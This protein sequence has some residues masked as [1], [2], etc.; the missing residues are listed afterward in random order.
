MAVKLT[1]R[2]SEVTIFELVERLFLERRQRRFL[3]CCKTT[4]FFLQLA[5]AASVA[6]FPEYLVLILIFFRFICIAW[7]GF[8]H[9]HIVKNYAK[10]KSSGVSGTSSVFP[11]D[12]KSIS[13]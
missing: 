9:V 4:R 12:L 10:T 7:C 8:V 2:V 6:A 3:P 11:N 13:D 5:A 1:V